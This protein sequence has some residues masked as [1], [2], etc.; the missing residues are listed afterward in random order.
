[1]GSLDPLCGLGGTGL[2]NALECG[3]KGHD[4]GSKFFCSACR[5]RRRCGKF[6]ARAGCANQYRSHVSD[7]IVCVVHA[8]KPRGVF[9]LRATCSRDGSY[10]ACEDQKTPRRTCSL[11]CCVAPCQSSCRGSVTFGSFRCASVATSGAAQGG[12]HDTL[13]TSAG[14]RQTNRTATS[15]GRNEKDYG[16]R[17]PVQPSISWYE[18]G[19]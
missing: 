19:T 10:G 4:Q 14:G 12:T 11:F 7:R 17:M 16:P 5:G 18:D 3:H 13:T 1:M 8:G 6:S 9:A 2:F 15:A